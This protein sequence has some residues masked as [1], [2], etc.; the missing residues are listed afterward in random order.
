MGSGSRRGVTRGGS[1]PGDAVGAMV[2]G[3]IART[4]ARETPRRARRD[5]DAPR[6][7][8]PIASFR[9]TRRSKGRN[10]EKNMRGG[11]GGSGRRAPRCVRGET[12]MDRARCSRGHIRAR[13]DARDAIW[14]P[15]PPETSSL[16]ARG[17]LGSR[18]LDRSQTQRVNREKKGW[19][20]RGVD[21][22]RRKR[23]AWDI[24]GHRRG[25]DAPQ[26]A[27]TKS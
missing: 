13:G 4:S 1:G 24:H 16:G 7:P 15:T 21:P 3:Q 11:S 23:R 27:R 2:V 6:P 18:R 5:R 17:G 19:R 25:L 26:R 9:H 12:R 14:M 22:T 8:A 20:E 10:W